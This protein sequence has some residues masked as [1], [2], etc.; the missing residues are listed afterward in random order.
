MKL[1][2][3]LTTL[4]LAA[5][6]STQSIDPAEPILPTIITI[7]PTRSFTLITALPTPITTTSCGPCPISTTSTVTLIYKRPP[8]CP[9]YLCVPCRYLDVEKR[10]LPTTTVLAPCCCGRLPPSTTTVTKDPCPNPC[11]CT[12]TTTAVP[13]TCL[14]PSVTPY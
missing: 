13:T 10:Q 5:C 7:K 8:L 3:I 2:A 6:I 14:R 12:I 9:E 11:A 4:T 1:T